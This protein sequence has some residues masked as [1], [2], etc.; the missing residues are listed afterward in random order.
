MEDVFR[1]MG[2]YDILAGG[3]VEA[4]ISAGKEVT[5]VTT[6]VQVAFEALLKN[7]L[8]QRLAARGLSR[9]HRPPG[10]STVGKRS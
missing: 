10:L 9:A 3:V 2:A 8:L 4:A 6:D 1:V 5:I 7:R